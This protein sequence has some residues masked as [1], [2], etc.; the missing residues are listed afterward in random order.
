MEYYKVGKIVNTQGIRGE[1]RVISITDF[2]AERFQKGNTVYA[3]LPTD[4]TMHSLVIDGVRKHK[5][6]VILHFAGYPNINDVE[7]L[8]PSDLFVD[9]AALADDVLAEGEYYYHDI[10]GL[11]VISVDGEKIGKIKEILAP[12]ANDVWVVARKGQKD[13]LLP[14]IDQVIKKVDLENHQ[15]T[16]EVMEGLDQ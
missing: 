2:E 14:K 1:V 4:E 12:G 7:F 15:V 3:Q 9:E 6:F 10:I 16:V 5:N 13:L 8:K 11:D